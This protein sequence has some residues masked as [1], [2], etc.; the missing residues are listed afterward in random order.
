MITMTKTVPATRGIGIGLR[1]AALYL[2]AMVFAQVPL[3]AQDGGIGDALIENVRKPWTGDLD[4]MIKRGFIRA[5]TTYNPLS[6]SYNGV[7]QR[8]LA[9][10]AAREFEKYLRKRFGRRARNLNV[11]LIPVPRDELFPRLLAGRGDF[12][13]A[14]LTITPERKKIV[15][16][17]K[18]YYP[19]V[20]ELVVTGPAA[21]DI[22]SFD[23][24]VA[25]GVHI[26]R[27]SSYFEHLRRLNKQRE[28]AGKNPIP[29]ET[30]DE[31]LEDYD[32]LEMVNAGIIPA[33]IVDSHKMELWSQIYGKIMVHKGLAV[34]TGG[35]IAWAV[36]KQ[37]QQLL[38]A[39]N[40][41]NKVLRKGSL[42][43]NILIKR[44]MNTDWID[45]VTAPEARKKFQSVTGLLQK[46]SRQYDFD[47]LMI[48]A[49]GYQESKLDQ[50]KRSKAGA[51]GVMQVMPTT[52]ADP[53][54]GIPDIHLTENNI[55][56]G[57]KYLRFIR[58]T[59]FGDD[60]ISPLDRV[61]FSFG[62]YN[63]GPRSISRA[64]KRAKRM[65][66]DPNRWFGHVEVAA[67]R[68]ISR[69]PVTY[70]RNIYKYFVTYKKL[71]KA[72]M[73]REE[74]RKKPK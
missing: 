5:L 38:K 55:H 34:N 62:A 71:E 72:R 8:G 4:G 23:D 10:D 2:C 61:L 35:S 30:A 40:G 18:P 73:S 51:V 50:S 32:L 1:A 44:Y 12:A 6:F 53:K 69:E 70:V 42:L 52:A 24:L 21:A 41:F 3:A 13:A 11:V 29:V 63:A 16:F 28:R 47:W 33:I 46:Y 68:T 7:E 25:V 20:R 66:L 45:N 19:N 60:K 22:K 64:S 57:V 26:R 14:N 65:G 54:V 56:A 27:S 59:Y 49:Q 43:G 36:R 67:A 48:A 17:S 39:I 74:S 37:S 9:V 58:K 15:A 31:R